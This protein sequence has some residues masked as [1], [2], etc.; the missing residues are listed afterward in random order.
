MYIK[1]ERFKKM[2]CFTFSRMFITKGYI[3]LNIIKLKILFLILFE[4][5]IFKCV[6]FQKV[7]ILKS[8]FVKVILYLIK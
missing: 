5:D 6:L 8:S 1:K 2:I 7:V 4:T 3:F